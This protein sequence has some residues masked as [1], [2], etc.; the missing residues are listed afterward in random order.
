MPLGV[1]ETVADGVPEGVAD[2]VLD[3]VAEAAATYSSAPM[4][5]VDPRDWPSMSVENGRYESLDKFVPC[6]LAAVSD[7]DRCRSR[8]SASTKATVWLR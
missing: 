2:G 7:A 3:G 8:L 5:H 4:S 1:A 6:P